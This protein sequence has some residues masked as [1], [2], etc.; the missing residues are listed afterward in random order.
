MHED[1]ALEFARWLSPKFAIWCNDRI[2]ELLLTGHTE[3]EGFV[4]NPVQ[5]PRPKFTD[6]ELRLREAEYYE[7]MANRYRDLLPKYVQVIDAYGLKALSGEMLLPLP[8]TDRLYTAEEIAKAVNGT[9][10]TVG[11]VM[12]GAGGQTEEYGELVVNITPQGKQVTSFHYNKA[13][14]D[15]GVEIMTEYYGCHPNAKRRE[16]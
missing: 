6:T 13:G 16:A 10:I 9:A 1:A 4:S 11:K 3:T 7:R 14:Y 2:K 8:Q 15:K 5:E 12:K